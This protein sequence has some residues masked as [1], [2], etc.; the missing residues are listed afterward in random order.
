VAPQLIPAGFE[1]RVPVP[2][3]DL[4]VVSVKLIIVNVAVTVQ[5][6]VMT[7]VVYVVPDNEPPQPEAEA[8]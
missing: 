5:L 6:P 4:V 2:V 3:P 1:V 8:V 7:P